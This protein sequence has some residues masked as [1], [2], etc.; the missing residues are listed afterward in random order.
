MIKTSTRKLKVFLCHASEDKPS[1]RELYQRLNT[2][3]WID[4]WL[5]E[6]KLLP[7]QDWDMEIEK[8][9]EKSDAVVVFVSGKSVSKEGYLQKELR[10]VLDVA[11]QK[12]EDVIY[13]IP[14]LLDK[15]TLPRRLMSYQWAKLNKQGKEKIIQSLEVRARQL[16]VLVNETNENQSATLLNQ[17]VDKKSVFQAIVDK[18]V[19]NHNLL[20]DDTVITEFF[21]NIKQK[22]NSNRFA[23]L[24]KYLDTLQIKDVSKLYYLKFV[25][26]TDVQEKFEL[27]ILTDIDEQE[28]TQ[29]YAVKH[30][31]EAHTFYETSTQGTFT[32][33]RLPQV[34][35]IWTS[36]IQAEPFSEI[37]F[38]EDELFTPEV[39][40]SFL[41]AN[42]E[43]SKRDLER[44]NSYQKL[45]SINDF[46][47][48][49]ENL[50]KFKVKN[51][52]LVDV[53][54]TNY[55]VLIYVAPIYSISFTRMTEK[56]KG[57]WIFSENLTVLR[58]GYANFFGVDELH[59]FDYWETNA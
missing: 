40:S 54:K 1:V 52:K 32:F 55:R 20:D 2:E 59:L 19:D 13:I 12:P 42:I 31:T 18:Y 23:D 28:T 35:P 8:A 6:D 48:E 33:N 26:E 17:V 24:N 11:Q 21:K 58:K 45:S 39:A 53:Y 57:V 14:V 43:L 37:P 15:S 3:G 36:D 16:D 25:L 4:P 46:V 7:G 51:P 44:A 10:K 56:T 34:R 5:D 27:E 29:G 41:K 49:I 9:V 22:E 30:L 50:S 47:F 38:G